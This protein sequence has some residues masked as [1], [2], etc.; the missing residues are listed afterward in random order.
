MRTDAEDR[1]RSR[2]RGVLWRIEDD[3]K[4]VERRRDLRVGLMVVAGGSSSEK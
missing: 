1:S 4:A 3:V 2:G